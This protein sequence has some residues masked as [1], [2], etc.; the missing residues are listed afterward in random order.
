MTVCERCGRPDRVHATGVLR[1]ALNETYWGFFVNE[2]CGYYTDKDGKD[3]ERKE[4][5]P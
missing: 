2:R 3:L 5:N 1:N 4:V